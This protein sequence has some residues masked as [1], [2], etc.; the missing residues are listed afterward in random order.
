MIAGLKGDLNLTTIGS[1][2]KHHPGACRTGRTQEKNVKQQ[3]G[4]TLVE[5]AVAIG[6]VA[7]LSGIIIPLVIKNLNDAKLARAR[8]D[9]NVIVAAIVAQQK[10]IG[11]RPMAPGG[12][13]GSS[14]ALDNRWVSAGAAPQNELGG[15][16]IPTN[17]NNTFENLFSQ[18]RSTAG[19]GV[20]FGRPAGATAEHAYKGPYLANDVTTK[21]DPWGHTYI[22]LG[23][24]SHG[25]TTGGPIWVVSAGPSGGILAANVTPDPGVGG[26]PPTPKLIWDRGGVSAD[27]L[28]VRAN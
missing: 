11:N 3:K 19:T 2:K 4:F 6:I 8:N 23:Y 28:A 13:N 16:I 27:N 26:L 1:Y 25:Q 14:G 18:P 17:A 5:A 7:I 9:I 20:L 10:D 24:N 21:S 22:I 15:N 12:P